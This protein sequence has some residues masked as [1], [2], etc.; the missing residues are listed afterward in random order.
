ML[1]MR[2]GD[3]LTEFPV[4][5][6]D[7]GSGWFD[8][9]PVTS[10]YDPAFFGGG[11]LDRLREAAAS[12][13]L[14]PVDTTGLRV[15]PPISRPQ[16][17][18]CIGQNYAAH[19][20]ESGSAAPTEPIVFLKHP[21]TLRGPEDAVRVPLGGEKVDWEVELGVVIGRE[22]RYLDTREEA[23]PCVAGYTIVNDL[24]ER[25]F[26]ME[27][28][29]GQW[30]KGKSCEDFCPVGP[31]LAVDEIADPQS[32]G[33]RSWVNGEPRQDSTTADMLFDVADLV[34]E[35]SQFMVLSPGDL[36]STGTPQG[37]AMS[38]R[39]PY[40]RAGDV[41]TL[42]IDGLGRQSQR[43]IPADRDHR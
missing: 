14:R 17:I 20:A 27:R 24:S 5:S 7:G 23:L 32:L 39:Y 13:G 4:V 12:G 34:R 41:M 10:D 25:A 22:A 35:L 31:W 26:Q 16:A 19:A 38:G 43:L 11:G 33:L 18:L 30:S 42:E 21:N 1:L 8:A 37:V 9:R 29:G 36:I 28:S 6:T 2:V 15:G 40:L 3:P